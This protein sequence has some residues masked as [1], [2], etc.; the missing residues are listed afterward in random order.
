MDKVIEEEMEK[1]LHLV[2]NIPKPQI[3]RSAKNDIRNVLALFLCTFWAP[4]VGSIQA[5]CWHR[6][7]VNEI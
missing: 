2:Y 4:V 1:T 5:G 7:K 3:A 6:W